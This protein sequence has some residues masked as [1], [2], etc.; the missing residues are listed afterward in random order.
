MHDPRFIVRE[1]AG[2]AITTV[3]VSRWVTEVLVIDRA[4][5]HR[6]V[7]SSLTTVMEKRY[8]RYGIGTLGQRIRKGFQ[9]KYA[10]ARF[11]PLAKRRE[12]AAD[13]A[14]RLNAENVAA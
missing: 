4:Y 10:T 2:Y 3:G 9:L 5:C 6:V 11:W 12:Y 8:P 13:L 1:S 14:A 7:W